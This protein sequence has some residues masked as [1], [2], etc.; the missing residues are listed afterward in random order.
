[1]SCSAS[2]LRLEPQPLPGPL[3]QHSA[4]RAYWKV[5]PAW[6][7]GCTLL[8]LASRL[9][10][11]FAVILFLHNPKVEAASATAQLGVTVRVVS[12]CRIATSLTG[13]SMDAQGTAGVDASVNLKCSKGSN[14]VVSPGGLGTTAGQTST[15]ENGIVSYTTS[16]VTSAGNGMKT[17]T[18]N[19]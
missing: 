7:W 16:D 12:S 19:F 4:P 13:N 14:A 8:K 1:M 10:S 5:P 9:L 17:L 15:S 18:I 11:L 2:I 3:A 6:P